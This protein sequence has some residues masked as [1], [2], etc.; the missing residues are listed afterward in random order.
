MTGVVAVCR[1]HSELM[2]AIRERIKQLNI[3]LESLEEAAGLPSRYCPKILAPV[4]IRRVTPYTTF[5]LLQALGLRVELV[6]DAD[7]ME[8][9]TNKLAKIRNKQPMRRG[10]THEPI[11]FELGPDFYRRISRLGNAARSAKLSPEQRMLIARRAADARWRRVR[12]QQSKPL[13]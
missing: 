6:E 8:K 7:A 1:D 10:G 4:P 9:Y 13:N 5:L 11:R 3:T 2:K 12:D